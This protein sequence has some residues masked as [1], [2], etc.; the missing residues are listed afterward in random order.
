MPAEQLSAF[1]EHIRARVKI[2]VQA[3]QAALAGPV[4][5]EGLLDQ[6]QDVL[7]AGMEAVLLAELVPEPWNTAW[8]M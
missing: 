6:E 5:G 8:D 2:A 4:A 3:I 1:A 7:D